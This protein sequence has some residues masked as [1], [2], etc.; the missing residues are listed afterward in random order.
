MEITTPEQFEQLKSGQIGANY[1]KV[2]I[3]H[4]AHP[5]VLLQPKEFAAAKFGQMTFADEHDSQITIMPPFKSVFSIFNMG[6]NL[7]LGI[8][9]N[10]NAFLLFFNPG[11]TLSSFDYDYMFT[12]KLAER[13]TLSMESD[14]TYEL[15]QR[16]DDM[17]GM[18][19]LKSLAL[20]IHRRSYKTIQVKP[21]LKKL[22]SLK[23]VF[24]E[25][26]GLSEEEMD[27]FAAN[28]HIPFVWSTEMK[29]SYVKY[30]KKWWCFW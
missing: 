10:Y 18:K 23:F 2:L 27:E 9:A 3:T 12:W 14:V 28:Q 5:H 11:A 21:F 26:K 15:L 17:R 30:E 4:G 22:R 7:T 25:P 29:R 6:S 24:L 13:L 16:I 1:T 20:A 8:P 19:Q